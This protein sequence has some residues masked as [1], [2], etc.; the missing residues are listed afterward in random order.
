MLSL[1]AHYRC[2][3]KCEIDPYA[4]DLDLSESDASRWHFY[5]GGDEQGEA[6]AEAGL[7]PHG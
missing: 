4:G 2:E 5:I 6:I 3:F 7:Y 1:A